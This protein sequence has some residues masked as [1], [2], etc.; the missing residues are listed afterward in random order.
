MIQKIRSWCGDLIKP[1]Y[2]KVHC[3]PRKIISWCSDLVKPY[4][5]KV[6]CDSQ[7]NKFVW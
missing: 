6:H 5:V 1:H 4:G 2:V 7:N 3:D